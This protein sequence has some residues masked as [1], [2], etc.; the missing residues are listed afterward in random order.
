MP[1]K[2]YPFRNQPGIIAFSLRPGLMGSAGPRGKL[3]SMDAGKGKHWLLSIRR[4]KA[5]LPHKKCKYL[6]KTVQS[7]LLYF[8]RKMH[9]NF[10]ILSGPLFSCLGFHNQEP[11]LPP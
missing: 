8:S 3:W 1:H 2:V 5:V 9:I 10:V 7:G 11:S 4:Q 6:Q